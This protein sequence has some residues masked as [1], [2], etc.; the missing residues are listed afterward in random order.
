MK[1]SDLV[2]KNKLEQLD[3]ALCCG[4]IFWWG[5]GLHAA[6]GVASF[7]F[8]I[9]LGFL[10]FGAYYFLSGMGLL[11]K[12]R[13]YSKG[14]LMH[15]LTFPVGIIASGI[16]LLSFLMAIYT[17]EYG[18]AIAMLPSLFLGSITGLLWAKI[19]NIDPVRLYSIYLRRQSSA[20]CN[21]RINKTR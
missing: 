7:M 5:F 4:Y 1:Y 2:L 16:T 15:P 12:L 9:G 10:T 6:Y 18:V 17:H 14:Y 19:F 11:Q 8:F 13:D 21:A 3:I 20:S